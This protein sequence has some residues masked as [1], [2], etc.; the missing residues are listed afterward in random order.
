VALGLNDVCSRPILLKKAVVAG[1]EICWFSRYTTVL[2][3]PIS[4]EIPPLKPV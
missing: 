2:E 3:I 4:A 1:G